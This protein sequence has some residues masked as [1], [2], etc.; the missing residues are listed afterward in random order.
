MGPPTSRRSA[1]KAGHS[2]A[3]WVKAGN[4]GPSSGAGSTVATP[5]GSEGGD[6]IPRFVFWGMDQV[7]VCWFFCWGSMFCVTTFSK[8]IA[9]I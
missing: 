8:I 3:R 6:F 9:G 4:V 5:R 1:S 2:K 7:D